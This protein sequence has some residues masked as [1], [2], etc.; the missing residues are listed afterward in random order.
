MR[1][2]DFECFRTRSVT[3]AFMAHTTSS[4]L[5]AGALSLTLDLDEEGRLAAVNLPVSVP[6][7]LDVAMLAEALRKLGKM[8]LALVG[9][10]FSQKVWR[11]ML[12]IP[13]G[14]ALTYTELARAAG[15][16]RASRAVGNAC[17][18]NRLP[19]IVPC[20]RVLAQ[21][22]PGGFAYGPEWK[23]KLLELETESQP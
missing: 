3:F 14:H 11:K 17:A 23:S 16:P 15:S 21:E 2:W 5:R 18:T 20:H 9:P 12:E 1:S 4:T 22:G 6:A 19:L 10:P 8:E 13:W 7:D